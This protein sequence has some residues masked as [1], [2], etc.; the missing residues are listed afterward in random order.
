VHLINRK[1]YSLKQLYGTLA[2][3][4]LLASPAIVSI[5]TWPV[6]LERSREI[7][8]LAISDFAIQAKIV[9]ENFSK[10][11]SPDFL[12]AN[13]DLNR[14][15]ATGVA[16]M[17]GLGAI[18]PIISTVIFAIK[19]A[20]SKTELSLILLSLFGIF[21]SL[22]GS[23]LTVESPPHS[24]R[25]NCA[26]IFFAVLIF[27]GLNKLFQHRKSNLAKIVLAAA[28]IILVLSFAYYLRNF[29]VYYLPISTELFSTPE[30]NIDKLFFV[31]VY[32]SK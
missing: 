14:R 16:G 15:H 1:I 17:I 21:L 10:L 23:A 32:L 27:L 9:F 19:K 4:C 5:L 7:S 18:V 13:G 29:F 20:F 28:I 26:W 12:F 6:T 2:V 31:K 8:I 11:L 25:A 24:L 22:L 30:S 3:S